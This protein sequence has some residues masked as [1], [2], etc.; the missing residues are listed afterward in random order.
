MAEKVETNAIDMLE[1]AVR[2]AAERGGATDAT[3]TV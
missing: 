2:D 1:S 3:A